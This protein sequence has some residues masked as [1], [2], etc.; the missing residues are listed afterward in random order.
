M[1]GR[2]RWYAGKTYSQGA[3]V[4]PDGRQYK[5][6]DGEWTS[7]GTTCPE[8]DEVTHFLHFIDVSKGVDVPDGAET[9]GDSLSTVTIAEGTQAVSEHERRGK[10]QDLPHGS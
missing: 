4:C 6:E 2:V 8:V 3:V 9:Q 1:S 5:C 7:L 10:E